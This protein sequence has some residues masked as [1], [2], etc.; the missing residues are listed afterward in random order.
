M[1][2]DGRVT[3][4]LDPAPVTR[5]R[6]PAHGKQLHPRVRTALGWL[7]F[8]V[9]VV[10][11]SAGT[12]AYALQT[13]FVPTPSMTPTLAPGDR[14]IVNK[15][16]GTVHRGDILVFKDPPSDQG[17]PPVLVKRVVGLPG[18]TISSKGATVYIN[19]QPLAEPWLPALKGICTETSEN[20][21]TQTI[22]PG[23]YF[24]MGDCRGDSGD[25]RY[26]GTLPASDIIGK[27][28]AII[29]RHGHPWM[30]WF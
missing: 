17:G 22:R 11:V 15:L 5:A 10:L 19:G 25:S 4:G 14:I 30:H 1:S 2:D 16:Y 28:D 23:R 8:I 9:I 24:M 6:T 12:R 21:K 7:V 27:V 3:T 26:W 29:W 13:Y 18:E 20:I